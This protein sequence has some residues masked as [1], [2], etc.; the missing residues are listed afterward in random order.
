[1]MEEA[2]KIPTSRF[3]E[4]LLAANQGQLAGF[5]RWVLKPGMLFGAGE[6]WWGERRRRPTPHEGLDLCCFEDATGRRQ[7]L[8]SDTRIP[9]TFA[10]RIIRIT[11]DFLGKS[12]YL[13]HEIF[14]AAGLKLHTIYGHLQPRP[15]LKVGREVA[16]GEII[17]TIAA[18]PD[19]PKAPSAPHLHITLAWLPVPLAPERLDWPN[20]GRDPAITL[21]DP[22]PLLSLPT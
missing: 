13:S 16:A 4:D 14:S 11:P 15:A 17:G 3:G 5:R 7:R 9:A 6:Q 19:R 1:M 20:L 21:I 12:V 2:S 8:D 22:R 18:G 10:G